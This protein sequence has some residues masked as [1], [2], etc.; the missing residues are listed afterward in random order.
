MKTSTRASPNEHISSRGVLLLAHIALAMGEG[1]PLSSGAVGN[2]GARTDRLDFFCEGGIFL[3]GSIPVRDNDVSG[4][5]ASLGGSTHFPTSLFGYNDI[6]LQDLTHNGL[7][8]TRSES[9]VCV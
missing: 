8:Q 9:G 1:R 7:H 4:G 6:S 5:L 2:G 3:C